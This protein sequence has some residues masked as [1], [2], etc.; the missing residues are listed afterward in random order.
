MQGKEVQIQACA[1]FASPPSM[2]SQ[3]VLRRTGKTPRGTLRG[4]EWAGAA[5]GRLKVLYVFSGRKR[6]NS[7]GGYLRIFPRSMGLRL[8]LLSWISKGN[9]ETTS[10]CSMSRSGGCSVSPTA[11]FL[12]SLLLPPC[13]RKWISLEQPSSSRKGRAWKYFGRF[14][15]WSNEEA[16]KTS[17]A[18]RHDG[19]ARGLRQDKVWKNT[20]TSAGIHVAVPA[21]WACVAR[22]Y[23]DVRVF[24][25][26]L[27]QWV[28][29]AHTGFY[30]S[31]ETPYLE[32]C[33]KAGQLSTPKAFML[34]HCLRERVPLSLDGTKA[35]S[36]LWPLQHGRVPCVSAL[37]SLPRTAS[38]VPCRKGKA[39]AIRRGPFWTRR[40][41]RRQREGSWR[42]SSRLILWSRYFPEEMAP[43][44][45]VHGRGIRHRSRMG[46]LPSPGWWRRDKRRFPMSKGWRELSRRLEKVV[47]EHVGG[48]WW[49][50]NFSGWHEVGLL[51]GPR[52][53]LVGQIQWCP[54]TIYP[55]CRG[56]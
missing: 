3:N 11:N 32:S 26:G 51:V 9:S 30:W 25:A 50:R 33:S 49:R 14:F 46:D 34:G 42:R 44:G 36:A 21:I 28:G 45:A 55:L 8:K 29:E 27:W 15:L 39:M 2:R 40:I 1:A 5:W 17:W 52:L 10:P 4:Q 19:T 24:T 6:R 37:Q 35:A 13:A 7:V 47:T 41:Q 20:T 56:T 48:S 54:D 38:T 18:C 53:I 22:G 16:G 31:F 43:R 12:L 23:E